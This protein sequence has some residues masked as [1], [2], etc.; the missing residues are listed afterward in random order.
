MFIPVVLCCSFF[1]FWL[2]RAQFQHPY[3]KGLWNR[4]GCLLKGNFSG[5]LSLIV[6]SLE[7]NRML[8]PNLISFILLH[9]I[10]STF[11]ASWSKIS[12]MLHFSE[13]RAFEGMHDQGNFHLLI[14]EE[15]RMPM[16]YRGQFFRDTFPLFPVSTRG[17]TH[18]SSEC[19]NSPG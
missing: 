1:P 9:S 15:L 11:P 6:F 5:W 7:W 4:C 18:S 2:Q 16:P 17:I 13:P 10:P 14:L 19:C 3:S 12:V 8:G